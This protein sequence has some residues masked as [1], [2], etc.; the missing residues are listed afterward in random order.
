MELSNPHQYSYPMVIRRWLNRFRMFVT[1]LDARDRRILL[2]ALWLLHATRIGFRLFGFQRIQHWLIE[3]PAHTNRIDPQTAIDAAH[4]TAVVVA[5]AS[6][7]SVGTPN[8]LS[9]SLTAAALLARMGITSEIQLGVKR[10]PAGPIFHAWVEVDGQVI[11][12]DP[13]VASEYAP[14]GGDADGKV[15]D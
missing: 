8:C 10:T 1:G 14:F 11:N 13:E 9:R 3:S 12:D 5:V 7:Y 6:K 4:R 2:R 15:F